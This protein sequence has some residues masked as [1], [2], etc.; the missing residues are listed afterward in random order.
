M[1]GDTSKLEDDD[2]EARES[3]KQQL[4]VM[5][6]RQLDTAMRTN[7]SINHQ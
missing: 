3:S 2:K 4:K 1:S 6:E 5:V 7:R